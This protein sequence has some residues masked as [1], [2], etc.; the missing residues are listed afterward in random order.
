MGHF[1]L[2]VDPLYRGR[3]PCEFSVLTYESV[4][5]LWFVLGYGRLASTTLPTAIVSCSIS[6]SSLQ[7]TVA[8]AALCKVIVLSVANSP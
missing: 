2:H 8:I 4:H 6:P 5:M 1:T 3:T 7:S